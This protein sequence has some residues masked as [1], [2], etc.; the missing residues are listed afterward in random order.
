MPIYKIDG[1][2]DGL[3]KY[4][5]EVNTTTSNGKHKKL[6]RVAYGLQEAKIK[7]KEL[8][9]AQASGSGSM[10]VQEL[11]NKYIAQ[12]E[13]RETTK[14]KTISVFKNHILPTQK[15]IRLNKL[16][17]PNFIEWKT[18]FQDSNLS[19][20][21]LQNIYRT[22]STLLNWAVKM[23][24]LPKNHLSEVGNFKDVYFTPSAEKIRYYTAD[25][26]LKYNAAMLACNDTLQDYCFYVFFSI[27]FYT[28]MRKGEINA[29]RWSDI[30]NNIIH[31]RRSIS[32]KIK[33][34][35]IVETP[36]KTK[37]SYRDLQ[38][39][40]PLFDILKTHKE[41]LKKLDGFSEDWRVCGGSD[42]LSDTNIENHNIKYS[43]LAGLPHITIHEFRHT[44]A[45]ILCN[46][47]INIQEIARRLGH[48]NVQ[49]TWQTYSHLYPKEEERAISI[50]DKIK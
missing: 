14:D 43:K 11:Y 47:G 41:R 12:I 46:A 1:K 39:P 25:Q 35:A 30:D 17:K 38:M 50:L 37:T 15:D 9:A 7:E 32:Q 45:S 3:Q 27:A 33:G 10:T 19:I 20:R 49:I 44:H 8:S 36:P 23:E 13:V 6:V 2:K 42:C 16:N 18:Q 26:Y 28:G 4:R 22:Y 24:Y 40:K 48:S 34:K 29:L 5:V 31:V 21:M